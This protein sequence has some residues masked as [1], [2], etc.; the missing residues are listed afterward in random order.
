MAVGTVQGQRGVAIGGAQVDVLFGT[1]G[2]LDHAV[3]TSARAPVG[4]AGCAGDMAEAVRGRMRAQCA[5]AGVVT[6]DGGVRVA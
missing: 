6:V 3:M 2:P 4:R 5:S 1:L